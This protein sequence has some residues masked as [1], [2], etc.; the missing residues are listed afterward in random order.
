MKRLFALRYNLLLLSI[1][2]IVSVFGLLVFTTPS[3][4]AAECGELKTSVIDCGS[5]NDQTG[6]PVV[7][8]LVLGIQILTGA[9]G[10][11]AIGALV[12]AGMMYSSASGDTG[13]VAKA[14]EIIR[15]TIIGLIL[16]GAL[17]TIL[18]FLNPGGLFDGNT[19]FGAGGNG[20]GNVKASK[21]APQMRSLNE[22]D[23][24]DNTTTDPS[25]NPAT[26]LKMTVGSWNVYKFGSTK[27][28]VSGVK[29]LMKEKG[30]DILGMQETQADVPEIKKGLGDNYGIYPT[31]KKDPRK[32]AIAWNKS[33]FSV[34][35][36]G[37]F[38]GAYQPS[39]GRSREFV[40]IKFKSKNSG[41][42]FYVINTH[43]PQHGYY[44]KGD[45]WYISG[46]S[47]NGKA[48]AKH[49]GILT[50]KLKSKFMKD[51][52]PIFLTGDYNFN[53]RRDSCTKNTPCK[54]LGRDLSVKSGWA[55]TSFS[56]V[57]SSQGTIDSSAAIIDYVF[58][59]DKSYVTY[60]SMRILTSAKGGWS[61]SDHKPVGLTVTIGVQQ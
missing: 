48:Y 32:V 3:A 31:S 19:K 10:V 47:S 58:S 28:A 22:D 36:K 17:A 4:S 41:K 40:W 37:N 26:T 60:Q 29:T 43:F 61:G 9:V 23:T 16:F 49:M 42:V 54:E 33:K 52:V 56:D 20:L 51:N 27:N 18:N 45:K 5:V 30:V 21:L 55:H 59:W 15:N 14:K 25:N 1:L 11:V 8:F 13:Q 50:D 53:A 12:Y 35:S 39:E 38:V 6:S 46:S 34:V 2:G 57:P 24:T 44:K 7:A